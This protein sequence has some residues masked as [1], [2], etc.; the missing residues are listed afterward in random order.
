MEAGQRT[1]FRLAFTTQAAVGTSFTNIA[2]G[3][4]QAPDPRP[5][6]NTGRATVVL[7][8]RQVPLVEPP[9]RIV[10]GTP[11]VIYGQVVRTNAG[12]TADI[13]VMCRVLLTRGDI[14]P[15]RVVR[16]AD[17][18]VVVTTDPTVR[19]QVRVV[20]TAPAVTG[21]ARMREV[22]TYVVAADRA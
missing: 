2:V 17:G 10:P 22:Y 13:A 8:Q 4:A 16:A 19:V 20:T 5:D 14:A 18:S 7:V 12:Q 1:T 21:Y 9:S 15:C 3:S 6:N 11:T